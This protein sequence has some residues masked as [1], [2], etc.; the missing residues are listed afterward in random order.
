MA[1]CASAGLVLAVACASNS[2]HS[3]QTAPKTGVKTLATTAGSRPAP[4]STAGPAA[5]TTT[6]APTPSSEPAPTT[7]LAPVVVAPGTATGVLDDPSVLSFLASRSGDVTAAVYDYATGQLSVYRPG[8]SLATASV[9]KVQILETL[10]ARTQAAGRGLTASEQHLAAEMIEESDND[11]ATDL[12]NEVGGAAGLNALGAAVGLTD[13][14]PNAA[15]YW[16]LSTTTAADQLIL[17]R[18]LTDPSTTLSPANQAYALSLMSQIDPTQDWGATGGVAPGTS[19][20][21]KDGWLPETTGWYVNSDGIVTGSGRHYA[22][23]VLTAGDAS[24][25]YG[26]DTISG[27]SSLVWGLLAP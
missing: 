25:D 2:G 16:G 13:T 5:T 12:W 11:A 22:L 23:A 20:A 3:T 18:N 21:L 26:E 27:L 15:G 19:V 24:Q 6:L 10:L 17:L 14:G 1:A 4:T 9:V 7:T 8:T